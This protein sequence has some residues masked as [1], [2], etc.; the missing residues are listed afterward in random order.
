ME[1]QDQLPPFETNPPLKYTQSPNPAW[2]YGEG[3]AETSALGAK[4]VEGEKQGWKVV[5][6]ATED[7]RSCRLVGLP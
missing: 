7:P 1:N 3:C 5:D 4:W 2:K 6:T